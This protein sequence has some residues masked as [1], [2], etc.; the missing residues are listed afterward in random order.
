MKVIFHKNFDLI[1]GRKNT[2]R[3]KNKKCSHPELDSGS[4]PLDEKII[5]M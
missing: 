2:E 3:H 5:K 1:Q 4:R